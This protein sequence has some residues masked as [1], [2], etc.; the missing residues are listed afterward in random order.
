METP[1]S[2]RSSVEIF[3]IAAA[4]RWYLDPERVSR[5][6]QQRFGGE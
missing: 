4:N 6:G 2:V 3:N 1:S 5:L